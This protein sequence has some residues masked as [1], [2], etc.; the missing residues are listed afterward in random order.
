[1]PLQSANSQRSAGINIGSIMERM[2]EPGSFVIIVLR[3]FVVRQLDTV[4][5]NG[6]SV[7]RCLSSLGRAREQVKRWR[8]FGDQEFSGVD[9]IQLDRLVTFA[10][11]MR[12]TELGVRVR[13]GCRRCLFPNGSNERVS[14]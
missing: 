2:R 12:R 9:R 14:K 1:M 13:S 11:E 7:L 3:S 4:S 5:R 10:L 8:A 6:T